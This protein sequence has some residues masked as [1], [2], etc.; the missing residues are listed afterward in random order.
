MQQDI[1]NAKVNLADDPLMAVVDVIKWEEIEQHMQADYW[2]AMFRK[3]RTC[4]L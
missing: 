3:G 2:Q 1:A 4:T